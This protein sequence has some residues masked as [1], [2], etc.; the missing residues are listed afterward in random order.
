MS[1]Q[2]Q[3]CRFKTEK[4]ASKVDLQLLEP[5]DLTVVVVFVLVVVV[6]IPALTP[7]KA[8]RPV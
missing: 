5:K 8:H 2:K 6:V 3:K 4:V 7:V 1:L